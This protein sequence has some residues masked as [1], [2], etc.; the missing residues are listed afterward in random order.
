MQLLFLQFLCPFLP[1]WFVKV[2][3]GLNRAKAAPARN[4]REGASLPNQWEKRENMQP[5]NLLCQ[6][7]KIFLY[8]VKTWNGKNAN[9]K[10]EKNITICK[11]QWIVFHICKSSSFDKIY[12]RVQNKCRGTLIIFLIIFQGHCA[13]IAEFLIDHFRGLCLFFLSNYPE[14]SFI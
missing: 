12:S 2:P 4:I 1:T 3:R 13:F 11:C 5:P 8:Y 10:S 9:C 6:A 14:A 7:W